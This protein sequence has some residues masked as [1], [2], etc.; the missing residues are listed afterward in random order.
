MIPWLRSSIPSVIAW[1][2]NFVTI[3]VTKLSIIVI[4]TKLNC[5][6]IFR[7]HLAHLSQCQSL[8]HFV[9]ILTVHVKNL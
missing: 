9:M 3:A 2:Y 8:V 1:H 7:C 4:E 5:S 6:G